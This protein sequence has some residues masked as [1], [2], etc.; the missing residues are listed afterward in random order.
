LFNTIALDARRGTDKGVTAPLQDDALEIVMRGASVSGERVN[1]SGDLGKQARP[2]LQT[3]SALI[4]MYQRYH[5][6]T[7]AL[8]GSLVDH[9]LRDCRNCRTPR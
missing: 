3:F 9:H 8:Q 7:H 1:R 6:Q 5:K 4:G 2:R